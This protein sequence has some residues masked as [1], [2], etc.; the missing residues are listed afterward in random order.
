CSSLVQGGAG[1]VGSV[2][3]VRDQN[4]IAMSL[5]LALMISFNQHQ[6]GQLTMG[7]GGRLQSDSSHTGDFC[8]VLFQLVHQ[9]DDTLDTVL[10]LPRMNVSK[11]W[12]RG[13]TISAIAAG[14]P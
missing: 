13:H 12:Q 5:A 10:R 4:K 2:G 14:G 7:T 8:Q 6:A 3:I 1:R 9:L 11:T